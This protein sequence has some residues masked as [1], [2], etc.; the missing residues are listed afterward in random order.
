MVEEGWSRRRAGSE[1][2]CNQRRAVVVK[3]IRAAEAT[4]RMWWWWSRW[5][6]VKLGERVAGG[7][8]KRTCVVHPALG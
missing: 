8:R 1:R 6:M 2:G 5:L 7:G 4:E 3:G